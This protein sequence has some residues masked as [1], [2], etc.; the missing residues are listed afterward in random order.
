M[1]NSQ[2]LKIVQGLAAVISPLIETYAKD[3]RTGY[4]RAFGTLT[5]PMA[6]TLMGW[7][8]RDLF[9]LVLEQVKRNIGIQTYR[10]H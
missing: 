1:S 5:G 3:V 7:E 9:D 2:K 4:V 6:D 8:L 10:T